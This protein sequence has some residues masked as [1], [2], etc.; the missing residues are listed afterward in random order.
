MALLKTRLLPT[1]P[2]K[3]THLSSSLKERK[4][5][6]KLKQLLECGKCHLDYNSQDPSHV[7]WGILG[8]V[9]QPRNFVPVLGWIAAYSP[10]KVFG[11]IIG[12]NNKTNE[13]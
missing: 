2:R 6:D 7:G 4:K 8:A 5:G 12:H 13:Q 1:E 9:V 3:E 11:K 10:L